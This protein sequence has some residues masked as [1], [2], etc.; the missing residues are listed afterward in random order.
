MQLKENSFWFPV[1]HATNGSCLE[2][3]NEESMA[4][5]STDLHTALYSKINDVTVHK[6]M[7]LP[8][9]QHGVVHL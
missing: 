4:R 3:L 2:N 1:S 5:H 8:P 6:T 9:A 7:S